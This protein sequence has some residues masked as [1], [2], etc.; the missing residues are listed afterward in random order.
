MKIRLTSICNVK[1][2]EGAPG[3][4]VDVKDE[5]LAK[6]IIDGRGG[7]DIAKE[8]AKDDTAKKAAEK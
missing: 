1:G 2:C 5:E 7:V 6:R 8:K 3:D 4:V